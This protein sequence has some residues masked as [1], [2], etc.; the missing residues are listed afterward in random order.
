MKRSMLAVVA[1]VSLNYSFAAEGSQF[2]WSYAQQTAPAQWSK[3]NL[4]IKP[5]KG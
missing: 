3:L 5:A 4:N 1:L 2:D